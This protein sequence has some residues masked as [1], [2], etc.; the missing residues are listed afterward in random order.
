[1]N[2]FTSIDDLPQH[3]REQ[4][5]AQIDGRRVIGHELTSVAGAQHVRFI[6][7][8]KRRKYRNEPIEVDGQKF[9]SRWEA[10]RYAELCNQLAAGLIT[11][12]RRQVPFALEA[13]T[14]TGP[15]RVGA[16][17]AD[18]VYS[19]DGNTVIEDAK[20][21]PT[22][23]DKTYQWKKRHLEVQYGTRITEV[24]RVKSKEISK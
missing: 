9:D 5:R 22:R 24:E 1:M 13:W 2:R 16:Y 20:S 6:T 21:A 12:L 17:W 8:P 4:A 10:T 3:M 15:V 7:E 18:F 19:R 23:K 11:G 14:I